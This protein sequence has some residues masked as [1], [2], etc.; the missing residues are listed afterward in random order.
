MPARQEANLTQ[1]R[2]LLSRWDQG[3]I[4]VR[5]QILLDFIDLHTTITEPELENE[6]AQSASLF[7]TRIT[8]WLRITYLFGT[9]LNE[10]LRSLKVFLQSSTGNKFLN[11]F[12]DVGG[13]F[14][15]LEILNVKQIKEEDKQQ[16]LELLK[17]ISDNGRMYKELICQ[18]YGVRAIAECM[19]KSANDNTQQAAQNLLDCLSH[20]NPLY[21]QQV[22]KGLIAILLS[23]SAKAQELSASLLCK[24]Q[25]IIGR[26]HASIIEPVINLLQ[27]LHA[28]VQYQA[29]EL[30][31]ILIKYDEISDQIIQQLVQCLRKE[32]NALS[33]LPDDNDVGSSK[34]T[35]HSHNIVDSLKGPM[36]IYVQQAAAVKCIR[37]LAKKS[38]ELA[39]KF[40]RLQIVNVLLF[41][42]GNED[43]PESQ[44]QATLTLEY[45]VKHYPV[46]YDSVFKALGDQLFDM[47]LRDPDSLYAN[48][49]VVQADV[50]RSNRVIIDME[51]N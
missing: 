47:F 19:A 27:S 6:F 21:E 51:D 46:V 29:I 41:V 20:G 23:T 8:S 45:F 42:I 10:Q 5:R 7:F 11:E 25:P 16:A 34:P 28:E 18:S 15:L 48:M 24:I 43:Y 38:N 35:A 1:I 30:I 49:T 3:S 40:L 31:Q 13:L 22:Y 50:C 33:N 9:C 17:L 4:K 12:L 2:R 37:T 36:P 44:R 14:T 32:Q 26:V 39:N